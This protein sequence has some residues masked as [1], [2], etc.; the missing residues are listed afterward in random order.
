MTYR[1]KEPLDRFVKTMKRKLRRN[2]HKSHWK[3]DS[4]N[5][6][7]EKLIAETLELIEAIKLK[8]G[9]EE[10]C[11]DVANFAMMIADNAYRSK[12]ESV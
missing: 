10:E 3:Y 12:K 6:L 7:M 5:Q 1:Y 9:V 8:K 11:A 4:Q 2:V